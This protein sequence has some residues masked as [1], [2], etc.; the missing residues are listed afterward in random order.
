MQMNIFK[1]IPEPPPKH[2]IHRDDNG[3]IPSET[4]L[5]RETLFTC[6]NRIAEKGHVTVGEIKAYYYARFNV[7]SLSELDA[8]Q[9]AIAS[10]EVH[11]MCESDV[12]CKDRTQQI[13]DSGTIKVKHYGICA[14]HWAG[15]D[16]T[17]K[18]SHSGNGTVIHARD[19]VEQGDDYVVVPA[20]YRKRL[21]ENEVKE[22]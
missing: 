20:W 15:T 11:A 9:W 13:L 8:K 10:A 17:I 16:F 3:I 14:R 4:Q 18:L 5:A 22:C 2:R 12:I 1:T 6:A 21:A 7:A 19:V